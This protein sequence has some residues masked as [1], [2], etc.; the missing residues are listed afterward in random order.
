MSGAQANGFYL[1][2]TSLLLIFGVNARRLLT[3]IP[4]F[5]YL[6]V[7]LLSYTN[8]R[9]ER[10]F[11]YENHQRPFTTL[12]KKKYLHPLSN[13]TNRLNY[14]NN[15]KTSLLVPCLLHNIY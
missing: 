5:L 14:G 10:L 2:T 15:D 8:S 11:L 7:G 9:G 13:P 4:V 1:W 6:I 12:Y 3:L